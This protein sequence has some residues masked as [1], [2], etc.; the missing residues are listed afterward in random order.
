MSTLALTSVLNRPIAS[1]PAIGFFLSPFVGF[2]QNEEPHRSDDDETILIDGLSRNVTVRLDKYQVP[3]LFANN[4][5]DLYFAQGYVT[6]RDRLWQMDFMSYVAA[7]RL[8]ELFGGSAVEVDRY[9]RRMGVVHG[10]NQ[11]HHA[12]MNDSRS[13]AVLEA[14]TAGVNAYLHQLTRRAYPIEYKLI[15][16]VPEPWTTYKSVL[17]MKEMA[18]MLAS[19]TEDLRMTNV[20]ARYGNGVIATLFPTY[21]YKESPIIPEGTAWDFTPLP[22]PKQPSDGIDRFVAHAEEELNRSLGSNNWAV[23]GNRTKNGNPL[24]AND[25]HLRLS[26]PSTWYQLQLSAP[27]VNVCGVSLPG[28]P[29]V[30]I[31][32]N[33]QIAW[34]ITN[35]GADVTDWYKIKFRDSTR[36]E[37]AYEGGWRKVERRVERVKTKG[38][39]TLIDTVL[40]THQGPIAYLPN[41]KPFNT[42]APV[43]YA[44]R[45]IGHKA[46]RDMLCYYYLN[47]SASY[48]DFVRSLGFYESP[49]Q[50][51]VFASTRDDIALWVNGKFPLRAPQQGKYLLDGSRKEDDWNGFIPQLHNPH[52]LNPK[53]GFVSSANQSPT[54]PDY[55][56]Y[57]GWQFSTSERAIRINQRLSGMSAATVDSMRRLQNDNFNLKAA[58]IIPVFRQQLNPAQLTKEQRGVLNEVIDWNYQNE[59]KA[60]GATIFEEWLNRFMVEVWEQYLGSTDARPLK[61]PTI[62][63]TLHLLENDP[64]G[65]WFGR[66]QPPNRTKVSLLI[67]R[68][69]QATADTL[70]KLKGPVGANWQWATHKGTAIRHL[71]PSLRGFGREAILTGGG[72]GIVNAITGS[73]GPSWRMIVELGDQP[74]GYGVYPGGQSGNPGSRYYDDQ[75]ST[76]QQGKLNELIFL[77]DINQHHPG[78]IRELRLSSA[79]VN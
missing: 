33:K 55:P 63:V 17:V 67:Q 65:I 44:V 18:F 9:K 4:E 28:V 61:Y 73:T 13:K 34:G 56:Y 2:W 14:Y 11:A 22:I 39:G 68:S 69:F 71:M 40:Y 52:V 74:K 64:N 54:A 10:A 15:G 62:D 49:A 6:A 59:A 30:I 47:R 12:L 50:N 23:S 36:R 25:P 26:L 43:G 66:Y 60:V 1:V 20:R 19:R 77:R 16:Y 51:F 31:G 5:A 70:L 75:I 21:P 3:H 58:Q 27:G 29:N 79:K 45:W 7:G 32:F 38:E 37:Y 78:L 24:L 57:I 76:W 8:A 53:R 72:D 41:Q 48:T 35:V 46:S 42:N